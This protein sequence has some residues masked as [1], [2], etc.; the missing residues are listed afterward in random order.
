MTQKKSYTFLGRCSSL[1]NRNGHYKGYNRSK[2]VRKLKIN[3]KQTQ[4]QETLVHVISILN[5]TRY[6]SQ[7]SR[8]KIN[9]VMDALQKAN[10]V[11]NILLNVTDVPIQHLTCHQMYTYACTTF[12][13]LRDCPTYM[14]Q[15]ATHM[16]DN[17][18]AA[19]TNILSPDILLGEDST[20]CSRHTESQLPSIMHHPI[21]SD[22]TLHFY[23]YLKTHVLVA[24]EQFS[25]S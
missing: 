19:T 3:T 15:V 14:M 18:D 9:E 17:E 13:Y 21:S 16:M 7:V 12:A 10:Q 20:V 11:M 22:N 1:A 25:Y 24:E 8:Q 23:I 5:I 2:T 6:V 4:Q